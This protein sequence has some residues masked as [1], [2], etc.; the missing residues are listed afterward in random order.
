M[1]RQVTRWSAGLVPPVVAGWLLLAHEV[2]G[3]QL[4]GYAAYLLLGV[5]GPGLLVGRALLGRSPLLVADLAVGGTVGMLLELG[6]WAVAQSL[7]AGAHLRWWPLPVYALFLLVPRLRR[8]A[9]PRRYPERLG[10]GASWLLAVATGAGMVGFR[11]A[12]ELTPLDAGSV[13]WPVDVP[14]HLAMVELFTHQLH[15]EDPQVAGSHLAY[16]WFSA[17]DMAAA[18]LV[19]GQ[20]PTLVVTRLWPL[21]LV[22]LTVGMLVAA[23][24]EVTRRAG[25]AG[26][27]A[28]LLVAA[29][30]GLEVLSWLE[31]PWDPVF[32]LFSPSQ[33]YSYPVL[34][35]TV[36]LVLR[37][38]RGARWPVLLPLVALLALS[39][40]VKSANLPVLLSGLLLATTA[41]LGRG[42]A[43][44]R[45]A[46]L[47]ALTGVAALVGTVV[48]GA[49]GAAGAQVQLFSTLRRLEPYYEV[50][51][52]NGVTAA[53]HTGPLPPGLDRPGVG[54]VMGLLVAATLLKYAWVLPGLTLLRRR[55]PRGGRRHR[56]PA[57]WFLAG[58]G[59]AGWLLMLVVDQSGASQVYFLGSGTVVWAL[60]AGWGTA[61]L[62]GATR[63]AV[64]GRRTALRVVLGGA[65][66]AA[67]AVVVWRVADGVA[68]R[69]LPAP[70]FHP[71]GD[72]TTV[73]GAQEALAVGV[74]PVAVLLLAG[75]GWTLLRQRGPQGPR[76]TRAGRLLAVSAAVLAASLALNPFYAPPSGPVTLPARWLL[77]PAEVDA[78]RWLRA[79]AGPH[80][81]VATNVHCL[82][83]RGQCDARGFWVSALTGRR[84]YVGG[85]AYLDETRARGN[86]GGLPN[87]RQPF[88][89]PGRL[90]VNDALFVAPSSGLTS[91]LRD[92][93]VRWVFA[94][95]RRGRVSPALD[96]VAT[97]VHATEDV[98]V[99]RLD[100]PPGR[101]P[102]GLR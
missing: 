21:P 100:P 80:D 42:G 66:G 86:E 92:E 51:G 57:A 59:L 30:A 94:D 71:P 33:N 67:A 98:R 18:S 63:A 87:A 46:G 53:F 7:G 26:A 37:V 88:H 68:A 35:L 91:Y 65:A 40:G 10:A 78:A 52:L 75:V 24:R 28:G 22:A 85:W 90:A 2:T 61:A 3:G 76:G 16:H 32:A 84:T 69:V 70:G 47:A 48:I 58:V 83:G 11:R 93:G 44:R 72:R 56:D 19:S 49:G 55:G 9:L 82:A 14:W 6:A 12:L 41:A 60:L 1:W 39:P 97:L 5:L 13:N 15:P 8:H 34:L 25:V 38:L 89:D 45:P 23:A 20:D 43:W 62:L 79:H 96:D 77:S 29:P 17:A 73:P 99:Y 27:V 4:A 50:V 36:V 81:V 64:G 102:V 95:T 74:V 101:G 31:L 54:L